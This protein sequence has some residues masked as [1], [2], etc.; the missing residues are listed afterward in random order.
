MVTGLR[1]RF[2]SIGLHRAKTV[3]EY[4]YNKLILQFITSNKQKQLN[5]LGVIVID[6]LQ[7]SIFTLDLTAH[8]LKF[9]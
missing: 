8:W 9:H 1:S 5:C 3:Q 4:S 7:I 2:V 6:V